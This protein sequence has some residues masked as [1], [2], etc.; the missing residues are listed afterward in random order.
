MP[1]S[2]DLAVFLREGYRGM[3]FAMIEGAEHYHMPTDNYENLNKNSAY[4]YLITA[5]ATSDMAANIDLTQLDA[6][7]DGFYFSFVPGR[8]FVMTMAAARVAAS[9]L[10]VLAVAWIVWTLKRGKE[11]VPVVV[12]YLRHA[13][14]FPLC[15]LAVAIVLVP[16]SLG[17]FG[18]SVFAL[19]AS[20]MC[21]ELTAG[22][23]YGFVIRGALYAVL[24]FAV[25]NFAVPMMFMLYIALFLSALPIVILIGLLPLSYMVLAGI[26]IRI[27]DGSY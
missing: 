7:G 27:G 1:N 11:N 4:H 23:K 22:L 21:C 18:V 13:I 26:G 12:R 20:A 8:L 17:I 6:D 9:V 24:G 10:L 15:M 25:L 3:N 19:L 14:W 5:T 2:T 16:S